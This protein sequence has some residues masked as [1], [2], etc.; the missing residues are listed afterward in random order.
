[1][2]RQL[3]IYNLEILS[4]VESDMEVD[5]VA[6]VDRP[7]I[8]KNFLA[9]KDHTKQMSFAIQDE[10]ERIITGALM[11]AD[12]PIYRNDENGE[13]YVVFT[14]DTIKQIAQKFFAKGYQSNVNLM[15]DSGQR[16]DGLVMF[17]SW[18]T[19]SKRGIMPMKGF[20][21]VADGSWFGSFKVNNDEVW[22]MIKDG[23][24]KGFSVE[25][26]FS[27]K[28]A[29]IQADQVQ[30]LWS[31][32]QE[33]L[34]DLD[35]GGPG[36]GRRPEGGSKDEKGTGGSRI[37][38][39][40][41]DIDNAMAKAKESGHEID[42]MGKDL[43]SKYGGTVTP[44]NYKSAESMQR[45]VDN[46]YGGNIHELKDAVRNTVILDKNNIGAAT[47]DLAA[48]P[49]TLRIKEQKAE[50]DPLGYSG[51]I[52]NVRMS[53]G[54]VAEV[55]INTAHMIYAKNDEGSARGILGDAKYNEI[56][57]QTGKPGGVGHKLY[58]EYRVLHPVKDAAKRE[59]IAAESR[60]YYSNFR[61]F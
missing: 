13:Y 5:Y 19:D 61:K 17:E 57:K 24:V 15:H 43:A 16:L 14:K 59:K 58:E 32:I 1:M 44:L 30:Q 40:K 52:A 37:N 35:F 20:E 21:D 41:A 60:A 39:S 18:I 54:M 46:E 31:Q 33:I 34:T 23:M 2:E 9:F 22:Q 45:K 50:T 28:K 12:K 48:N 56:A 53:N 42:K 3:P 6:L 7:A 26:L 55:Q 11:L 8:D 27:Y 36:S 47:K 51:T 29:D 10:D 38:V 25:G 49:N 4:D